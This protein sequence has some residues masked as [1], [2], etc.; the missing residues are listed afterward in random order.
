MLDEELLATQAR[1]PCQ[2]AGSLACFSRSSIRFVRYTTYCQI[3]MN[4]DNTVQV[5]TQRRDKR[6]DPRKCVETLTASGVGGIK[7]AAT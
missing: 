3:A 4:I 2:D 5:D 1:L 6:R 7:I